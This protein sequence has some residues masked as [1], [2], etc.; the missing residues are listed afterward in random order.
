[1]QHEHQPFLRLE[2][3]QHRQQGDTDQIGQDGGLFRRVD[4][5]GHDE[6]GKAV[7]E[8]DLVSGCTGAQHVDA[9]APDHRREPATEVVDGIGVLPGEPQPRFLNCVLGVGVRAENPVGNRQ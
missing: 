3:T 9:D 7:V 8:G 2:R 1:V 4:V 5:L 6:F